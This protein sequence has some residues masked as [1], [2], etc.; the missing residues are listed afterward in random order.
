MEINKMEQSDLMFV[1][2]VLDSVVCGNIDLDDV[3]NA[4]DVVELHIKDLEVSTPG[5][6]ACVP[7]EVE[8]ELDEIPF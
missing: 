1:R 4:M 8:E 5:S 6:A 7:D 2:D 3:V